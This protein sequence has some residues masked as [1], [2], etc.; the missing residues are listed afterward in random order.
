MKKILV[1]GGAGYIGS[2]TCK[3]L[4]KSNFQ[5]ICFDNLS[6]GHADFVRWGDLERGDINDVDH[7]VNV[8]KKHQPL[9]IIHFAG[10][11]YVNESITNPFK[12]YRNNV[13]GT[14]SLLEAMRICD[15]RKIIFSS[16]CA[17][18]GKSLQKF[19]TEEQPQNP[20]NPYGHSKLMI[21]KILSDLAL[22][23]QISQ[24]SLRYFNAAGADFDCEIGENHQPETHLIPL[25]IAS[26][27]GGDSL[28]IFGTDF[29]TSDGTA[30]RDYVHVNDLARAHVM[31]L[32]YLITGG[33]SD[34]I[35]LG[36]GRGYSI[37]EIINLLSKIDV[38]VKFEKAARR[39]GEQE[40][41]VADIR[42]AKSVLKW[43]PEIDIEKTLESAVIW[44]K[45]L[46]S[47]N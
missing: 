4:A 1:T 3:L 27:F 13:A 46:K 47:I 19:I 40:S 28:K 12:Y 2:H 41:L 42:R 11:A 6:N 10:S 17:T 22:S 16:S 9:A 30:I 7:L 32:E 20:L 36:S 35:N 23:G 21:E 38:V 33:K 37:Y 44:Y 24:I 31:A 15:V 5:P 45:K 26:A 29:E 39:E 34:F 43:Q 25:A 14:L 18:Y 8:I